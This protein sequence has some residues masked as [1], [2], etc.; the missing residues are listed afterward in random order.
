MQKPLKI[1]LIIA[2]GF[3]FLIG[4]GF[5]VLDRSFSDM[6]G[7]EVFQELNSP[8]ARLKAVIFQRDC[9]ATTGFSTQISLIAAN[10]KLPNETGNLF[11]VTGHPKETN[12]EMHWITPNQLVIQHTT[13][14]TE[15]HKIDFYHGV[16]IYY[17]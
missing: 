14:L 6:C 15:S 11:A 10:T 9:G 3:I 5:F 1:V 13:G 4:T 12:I 7:N 2:A 16:R 8:D 17:K